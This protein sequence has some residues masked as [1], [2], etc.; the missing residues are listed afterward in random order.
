[1]S[2]NSGYSRYVADSLLVKAS[3][4]N[5]DPEH[6]YAQQNGYYSFAKVAYK[7]KQSRYLSVAPQRVCKSCVLAALF[8]DILMLEKPYHD[9][10]GITASQKIRNYNRNNS[11]RNN[12]NHNGSLSYLTSSLPRS[13]VINLT[14]VPVSPK[15]CL[16]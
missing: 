13:R 15:V 6:E 16:I 8:A 10:R 1:M 3:A 14:G 12:L 11:C 2:H 7:R 9:Y 5:H 4:A